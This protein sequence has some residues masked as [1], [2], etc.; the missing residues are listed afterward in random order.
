MTFFNFVTYSYNVSKSL[1]NQRFE[2]F[3]SY[4]LLYLYPTVRYLG[5]QVGL[6]YANPT[7]ASPYQRL[8]LRTPLDGLPAIH[9]IILLYLIL[10]T[11]LTKCFIFERINPFKNNRYNY[12]TSYKFKNSGTLF[13][14]FKK[15]LITIK[16][17]RTR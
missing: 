1:Y 11:Y 16:Y 6:A 17:H 10:Y 13:I 12:R 2:Q 5:L 8:S 3:D 7:Q 14:Q 15:W 4:F 9:H